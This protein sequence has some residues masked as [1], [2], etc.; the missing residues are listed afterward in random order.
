MFHLVHAEP[1]GVEGVGQSVHCVLYAA[2]ISAQHA[3]DCRQT[4]S[5][6]PQDLSEEDSK[7][8]RTQVIDGSQPSAYWT[9]VLS[10]E[11][12][13]GAVGACKAPNAI[14][15]EVFAGRHGSKVFLGGTFLDLSYTRV[16][17]DN[18]SHPYLEHAQDRGGIRVPLFNQYGEMGGYVIVRVSVETDLL[19]SCGDVMRL[20]EADAQ[21]HREGGPD[22]P[23]PRRKASAAARR[24]KKEKRQ[25]E[26]QGGDDLVVDEDGGGGLARLGGDGFVEEDDEEEADDGGR[27]SGD[28]GGDGGVK[29]PL[30]GSED[31]EEDH[32]FPEVHAY[33]PAA[34]PPVPQSHCC[35]VCVVQ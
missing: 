35:D 12:S 33:D 15:L 14:F 34:P 6:V 21:M 28:A 13:E 11:V 22:R 31:K 4:N 9:D 8:V 29:A 32:R 27:G 16:D 20:S 10:L 24:K 25:E 1:K 26:A 23:S 19:R 18:V 5:Y 7:V 3:D 30:L 17:A 2:R